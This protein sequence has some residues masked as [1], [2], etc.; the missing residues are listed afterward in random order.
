MSAYT[1]GDGWTP[2]VE[3]DLETASPAA[4]QEALERLAE[5]D[6]TAPPLGRCGLASGW[7]TITPQTAEDLLRRNTHN[8]KASL[9]TVK[10]YYRAMKRNGWKPTGQPIL[11]NQAG[12]LDDG[13]HRALAAYF[14]KVTFR[15][16]VVADV[17]VIPE[18]FAYIDDCKPRS[19]ADAL[20]TSGN[21]GLSGTIAQVVK[22]AW[23]WDAGALS[24]MSKQPRFQDATIPEVLHYASSH[25]EM[26]DAVHL[27]V[28]NFGKAANV[29]GDKAVASLFL[30]KASELHGI[31]TVRPFLVSVGVGA[32]LDSDSPILAFRERL[33]DSEH[34]EDDDMP[35]ERRLALLIKA[36]NLHIAGKKVGQRGL[37]VRDNEK[38]PRI[39]PQPMAQAAE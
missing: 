17:E 3:L 39:D 23:R 22:L 36:F 13:A 28:S 38:F 31:E 11:V 32:N 7:H 9:T 12:K 6:K 5:W 1:T 18:M 24:V 8:R 29:I 37:Y 35:K 16:Y 30:W 33:R 26:R 4:F 10:K 25:T 19:A 27:L 15:S 21:N 2:A 20:Y 14:G 34:D